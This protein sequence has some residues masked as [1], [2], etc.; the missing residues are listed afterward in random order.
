MCEQTIL[1]TLTDD[2]LLSRLEHLRCR[3]REITIE[4]LRHLNEVE[5]RKLHLKLGY[6]SLFVFC[7]EKL[8][9]SESAAGRRIQAARCLRRFCVV[10]QMLENDELSL[11]TVSLIAPILTEDNVDEV[12]SKVRRATR[13]DVD[14]LVANFRPPV[15]LRDRVRPV[16]VVVPASAHAAV[17]VVAEEPAE[18]DSR[19]GSDGAVEGV[20]EAAS[21]N[22]VET[23]SALLYPG[24]AEPRF[25]IQ[26]LASP[27]FMSKYNE[28]SALLSNTLGRISFEAVFTALLDDFIRRRSP[29]MRQLRREQRAAA[30]ATAGSC[31][32]GRGRPDDPPHRARKC[33]AWARLSATIAAVPPDTSIQNYLDRPPGHARVLG[34]PGSGKTTLLVD[35]Y[36]ALKSRGHC[37][38][39]VAF[40]R[41][42]RDRLLERV[43]PPG[44]AHLGVLPV[45]THALVASA[46]LDAATP[47]RPRTLRDVDELLVLGR[48]LRR[49]P[50]LL[51]SDLAAISVSSTFLRDL[52]EA[53]HALAQN[54]VSSAEARSSAARCSHPRG[55]DVL[56]VYARYREVCAER[57][58]VSFYDAAWHAAECVEKGGVISPLAEFDVVLIDDFHDLDPGQYRVLTRLVP[59]GGATKL[60]VFGDPTVARFS[61]RGTNDRF[62]QEEFAKDYAP[63]D[64]HLATVEYADAALCD[65][66][67]ALIAATAPT[68]AGAS[69][70]APATTSNLP[71]F[72]AASTASDLPAACPAR[73]CRTT[74]LLADDEIAEVQAVAAR[75]RAA[76]DSGLPPH[77]IAVVAR[78]ADRYRA[79][80]ELACH[81]WG[82]PVDAGAHQDGAV[83]DFLRSLVGSLGLDP[84]GRFAE[85]LVASPFAPSFF[86]G[87][88]VDTTVRALRSAYASKD[89]FQLE[90]MLV[91][92]VA[93]LCAPSDP[94]LASAADEWRRYCDVVEHAGGGA[95]LDE[96]RATYLAERTD[97]AGTGNRVT[98]LSALEATGRS[99]H[100][101]FVCGCAEGH[102]PGVVSRDG[103]I[104]LAAVARAL[105]AAHPDAARD[106]AARL[107]ESALERSE[108]ALF[109]TALT[110]A[111]DMLVITAPARVGGEAAMPSRILEIDTRAFDTEHAPRR[112]SPCARAASAVA[113]TEPEQARAQR[114]RALD[115]LAGWWVTPEAEARY[116]ASPKFTMGAS[117]LNSYARCPRQFFYRQVLKIKEPDSIYLQVGNLVHDALK[118]IIALGATRDEIR[119]ALQHAGTREIAER[120]VSEKFQDAGAWMRELS[121]KYLDDMLRAVAALEAEREGNYTVRMLEEAVEGE[122]E[123]MPFSGRFDRVD[124]VEGLGAVVIDYKVSGNVDKTCKTVLKKMEQ[125]FWQIPVYATMA[126]LKDVKP[127]AFVYYALPPGE[128]SHAVGVQLVPGVRPAPIPTGQRPHIRYGPVDTATIADAMARALEL[129]RSIVEG[130]CRYERVEDTKPCPNCYYARICQRSRA[131]I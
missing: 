54:G 69:P 117:K 84:D 129:H 124:D 34:P 7:T 42:H 73:T 24:R 95:S 13:R 92:R 63:D 56:V 6:S 94:A 108:N 60:E 113:R 16:R 29:R 127:A 70:A 37:P 21:T 111:T 118:E 126:T 4:I 31:V 107:D 10:E 72:A 115:P 97:R 88:D 66:I 8:G 36:R 87:S 82:V 81:E 18:V 46:I 122:I 64:I 57:G 58:L 106:I 15:R 49:E 65:T 5:R 2:D 51:S 68:V 116:P 1:T 52:L 55:R 109:L 33:S 78:D 14:V 48:L 110:R 9:Y 41:E 43:I 104:P 53:L 125:N 28:A 23:L 76:I 17:D 130:E 62:F 121:V 12:T 96:F 99:F 79:V 131:S 61:F 50:N 98:L 20:A 3:E 93:P 26:F 80:L 85:S 112:E 47:R 86:H 123:G 40:G 67:A 100:T 119:A 44:G 25:F 120:L 27:E 90:R 83:E 19:G 30:A 45:T 91:E 74:V 35:R 38:G 39:I 75:A 59:P 101:T 103:Y 11:S 22:S 71:L 114:L 128:K 102:F 77:C 89:G 32:T 105:E